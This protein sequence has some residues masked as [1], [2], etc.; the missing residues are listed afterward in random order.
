LRHVRLVSSRTLGEG[1]GLLVTT[2]GRGREL[3]GR[4]LERLAYGKRRQRHRSGDPFHLIAAAIGPRVRQLQE[5]RRQVRAVCRTR[6]GYRVTITGDLPWSGSEQQP[7]FTW[8]LQNCG[9]LGNGKRLDAVGL[10]VERKEDAVVVQTTTPESIIQFSATLARGELL[11]LRYAGGG[12]GASP[13]EENVGR[14]VVALEDFE[15]SSADL[16][17]VAG[18]GETEHWLRA[19][20]VPRLTL[21]LEDRMAI[22]RWL[23]LPD[24]W[25]EETLIRALL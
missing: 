25:A 16:A 12:G 9:T 7:Y 10:K 2:S 22:A 6:S 8:Q 17:A 13:S 24:G 18:Y 23:Y 15:G 1:G 14:V 20:A 11:T 19:P 5:Q 21:S 3:Q 4:Y